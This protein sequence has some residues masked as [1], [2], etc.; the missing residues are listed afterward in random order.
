MSPPVSTLRYMKIDLRFDT[1]SI[2]TENYDAN[3]IGGT[4]SLLHQLFHLSTGIDKLVPLLDA[5]ETFP[6][7]TRTSMLEE[8][9][10]SLGTQYYA[11][12]PLLWSNVSATLRTLTLHLCGWS[13]RM[14]CA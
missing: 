4:P 1:N 14:C 10:L 8:L 11:Y 2:L 6:L 13:M 12:T 9:D 3:A 7:Q 5:G